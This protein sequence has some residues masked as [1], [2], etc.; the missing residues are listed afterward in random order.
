MNAD[1][2]GRWRPLAGWVDAAA[3]GRSVSQA[4]R[5][6]LAGIE[7]E[8]PRSHRELLVLALLA[9]SVDA[10]RLHEEFAARAFLD[11]GE[12]PVNRLVKRQ[13]ELTWDAIGTAGPLRTLGRLVYE[14]ANADDRVR[15]TPSAAPGESWRHEEVDIWAAAVRF[16]HL[17]QTIAEAL[18]LGSDPIRFYR[19][20]LLGDR[21]DPVLPNDVA[22]VAEPWAAGSRSRMRAV[23]SN[24]FPHTL[25]ELCTASAGIVAV[26]HFSPERATTAH[27]SSFL[28]ESGH[29][30]ITAYPPL[31]HAA[32]QHYTGSLHLVK[33]QSIT[34]CEMRNH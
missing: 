33:W 13:Q 26:T 3:T 15:M 19:S 32:P 27:P 14:R 16:G 22:C 5:D 30:I 1:L 34:V 17:A 29:P 7:P 9:V 25:F 10:S 31:A 8:D 2:L 11:G 6:L 20:L 21:P 12:I 4:A 28:S 18:G 24:A 23:A